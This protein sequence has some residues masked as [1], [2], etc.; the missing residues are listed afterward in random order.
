M[1]KDLEDFAEFCSQSFP[2]LMSCACNTYKQV[3]GVEEV[4]NATALSALSFRNPRIY[5]MLFDMWHASKYVI[6][7]PKLY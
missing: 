5:S 7:N 3:F 1:F 4:D 6:S 2:T